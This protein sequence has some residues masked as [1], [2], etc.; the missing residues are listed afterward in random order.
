MFNIIERLLAIQFQNSLLLLDRVFSIYFNSFYLLSSFH[1]AILLLHI[2]PK[3]LWKFVECFSRINAECNGI[4]RSFSYQLKFQY[5]QFF[6]WSF[7]DT[8]YCCSNFTIFNIADW[9]RIESRWKRLNFD[10]LFLGMF[11]QPCENISI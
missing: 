4:D 7:F 8:F 2:F 6:F 10:S 3:V 5:E 11:A 1:S 9:I